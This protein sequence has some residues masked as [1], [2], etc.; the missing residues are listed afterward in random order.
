MTLSE[1]LIDLF[2]SNYI[3]C[4]N[5]NCLYSVNDEIV[6]KI[7]QKNLITNIGHIFVLESVINMYN[8]K[9]P[10]YS[11]KLLNSFFN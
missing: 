11:L 1:D 7:K 3:E 10:E 5:N 8:V 9:Y 6:K 2:E 4:E